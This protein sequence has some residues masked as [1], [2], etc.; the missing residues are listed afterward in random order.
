MPKVQIYASQ[1]TG[2][3]ASVSI[4][5]PIPFLYDGAGTIVQTNPNQFIKLSKDL[6][7]VGLY[8]DGK[9]TG[10]SV[11]E[12]NATRFYFAVINDVESPMFG[13]QITLINSTLNTTITSKAVETFLGA[14]E[15]AGV[16]LADQGQKIALSYNSVQSA[17]SNSSGLAVDSFPNDRP[18]FNNGVPE[19]GA[20]NIASTIYLEN[21]YGTPRIGYNTRPVTVSAV[22]YLRI[23]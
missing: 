15:T 18:A 22:Y 2:L 6:T 23:K 5:V 14:G 20:K 17:Y 13:E 7:G 9:L 12:I 21:G 8:N 10:Q 16:R 1:I 11:T 3:V 19:S 4:G